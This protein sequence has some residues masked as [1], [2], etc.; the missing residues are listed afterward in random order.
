[1]VEIQK[2]ALK[3][4]QIEQ[5]AAEEEAQRKELD[6]NLGDANRELRIKSTAKKTAESNLG[7]EEQTGGTQ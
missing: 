7:F 5:Q 1:M 3:Q 2:E 4:L 6:Q